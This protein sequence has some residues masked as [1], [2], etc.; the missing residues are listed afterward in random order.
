MEYIKK[1]SQSH[2][3]EPHYFHQ[4]YHTMLLTGEVQTNHPSIYVLPM[5]PT[6]Y[7]RELIDISQ[8]TNSASVAV[9]LFSSSCCEHHL[10]LNG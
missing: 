4:Q 5:Q 6:Q 7:N 2:L 3:V 1:I 8:P 9:A 10:W